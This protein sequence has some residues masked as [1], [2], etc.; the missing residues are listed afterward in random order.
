[1]SEESPHKTL[2]ELVQTIQDLDRADVKLE[3]RRAV[4][5]VYKTVRAIED[6]WIT[7]LGDEAY[8]RLIKDLNSIEDHNGW[9]NKEDPTDMLHGTISVKRS[10]NKFIDLLTSIGE[11]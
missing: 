3:Q 1:M 9:V 6:A 8:Q 11:Q 7:Y 10:I 4:A 2:W 5:E